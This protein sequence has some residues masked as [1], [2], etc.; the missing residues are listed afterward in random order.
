MSPPKKPCNLAGH[1]KHT[2]IFWEEVK[3]RVKEDK[4]Q[5][6]KTRK[7]FAAQSSLK[8]VV[9]NKII[10]IISLWT[11]LFSRLVIH[12]PLSYFWSPVF[13]NVY[14][15]AFEKYKT[16]LRNGQSVV[17]DLFQKWF[18]VEILSKKGAKFNTQHPQCYIT[19][20]IENETYNT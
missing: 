6:T 18:F 15:E 16:I 11:L 4:N 9:V 3:M 19:W 20:R 1:A 8:T 5:E 10:N 14:H 12:S 2:W 7:P 13:V 17:R